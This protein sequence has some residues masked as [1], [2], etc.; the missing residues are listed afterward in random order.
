MRVLVQYRAA[1]VA[2]FATQLFWGFMR[3]MIFTAFY[4]STNRTMPMTLEETII[5]IWLSQGLLVMLPWSL[6]RDI[7]Q[8][9]RTGNV[10]YEMVRPVDLYWLWYARAI[11]LRVAPAV[12]RAI[13]MFIIAGLFL[14]LKAPVSWENFLFF[15]ISIVIAVFLSSAITVLMSV[16]LFWTISGDGIVRMLQWGVW[17]FSGLILPLPFF[18]DW[19]QPIFDFLPFRGIVDIPFRLYMG[20]IPLEQGPYW[21]LYQLVWTFALIVF[22]R[23]LMSKAMS[24]LVVQGG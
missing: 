7:A 15:I 24:K 12:L 23:W 6:D 4:E 14:G 2:G 20:N 17:F 21:V 11:A 13:P 16:T 5:Y 10:A 19:I 1:A 9:V 8:M 18:P 3:V 22:T